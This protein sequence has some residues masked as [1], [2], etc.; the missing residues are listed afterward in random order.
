MSSDCPYLGHGEASRGLDSCR[1]SCEKDS[2][3]NLV[4][5][6]RAAAGPEDEGEDVEGDCVMRSCADPAQPT[7]ISG[8]EGYEVWS[9]VTVEDHRCSPY[10]AMLRALEQRVARRPFTYGPHWS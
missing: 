9:R 5:F 2:E 1:D 7:L 3:C 10:A 6:R 8:V 4:N